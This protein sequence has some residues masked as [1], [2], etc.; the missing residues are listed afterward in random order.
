MTEK[1]WGFG[2]VMVPIRLALVGSSS[3]PD[4]FDICELIGKAETIGRIR[5]ACEK[6]KV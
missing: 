4:L 6:I 2:V 5:I 1:E 3:G